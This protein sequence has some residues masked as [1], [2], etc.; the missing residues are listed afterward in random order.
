MFKIVPPP[1]PRGSNDACL[2]FTL[3]SKNIFRLKVTMSFY[4]FFENLWNE[5]TEQKTKKPLSFFITYIVGGG[6]AAPE[7]TEK[8]LKNICEK[9]FYR[10]V[11]I[12]APAIYQFNLIIKI[13]SI[14][15]GSEVFNLSPSPRSIKKIIPIKKQKKDAETSQME[16]AKFQF[17]ALT[18]LKIQPSEFWQMT[19]TEFFSIL[20]IQQK[21]ENIDKMTLE[22]LENL[23]E[24]L[25]KTTIGRTA[26]RNQPDTKQKLKNKSQPQ[27]GPKTNR[28]Q[29]KQPEK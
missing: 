5:I 23:K 13:S 20:K 26:E 18:Q 7:L 27:P 9:W 17:Y 16:F 14:C 28:P 21:N 25:N 24:K 10:A 4:Q 11:K 6:K 2:Y 12:K 8:L 1:P 29:N 22:D 15:L 3:D 19:T